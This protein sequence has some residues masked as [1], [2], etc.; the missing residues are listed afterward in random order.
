MNFLDVLLVGV[1]LAMDASVVSI[2]NCATYKDKIRKRESLLMPLT[3]SIFQGVMPLIG[4]LLGKLFYG[5][6]EDYASFLTCGIFFILSAKI[7]FD[8]F[9]EDKNKSHCEKC[10][11]FNLILLLTQGLATSIDALAVGVT[12]GSLTF[13]PYLAVLT[14]ALV[15]FL[16]VSLAVIFGKFLSKAFGNYAEW[17]GAIILFFLSVKAL[18]EGLVG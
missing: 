10:K 14:I 3:F 17:A 2:A 12:F 11:P 7:V 5:Y 1:A 8:I 18:V 15:T 9:T 6:V 4:F 13:S 16:L